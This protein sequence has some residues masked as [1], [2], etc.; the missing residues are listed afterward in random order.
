MVSEEYNSLVALRKSRTYKHKSQQAILIN[1]L[2]ELRLQA[3]LKQVDLASR[4]DLPQSFVS[5]YEAGERS[6]D[7]LEL[8]EICHA[9][10]LPFL[11]FTKLLEDRIVTD[12]C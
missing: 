12:E 6:L 7:I 5:K 10:N 4:L 1:L 9:L 11:D 3:G 2:R 8:R